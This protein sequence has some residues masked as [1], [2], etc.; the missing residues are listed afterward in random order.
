MLSLLLLCLTLVTVT[1]A[2]DNKPQAVPTPTGTT[3]VSGR[4]IYED[5][6]QPAT[7][8][9]VQLIASQ[10]LFTSPK[11]LRIPTAITNERGEFSMQRVDAGEYY[12]LALPADKHDSRELTLVLAR[13]ADSAA[14]AAKLEQFKKKH[15]R[16][17]VDG[18]HNA[19]VNVRIPN[20]HFGTISGMVLDNTRQ[21]APRA[22]VHIVSKDN[23]SPGVSVVTDDEG[24]YKV[25]G[26]PKGEYV[27]SANPPLK[28]E[29]MEFQGSPGATYFPS[30]LLLQDSPPVV[31]LPDVDT[32]NVDITLIARALRSVAGTVRIHGDNSVAT[33]ATVRLV[34]KGV[35]N[36]LSNY[37]TS[38][39]Q[40]GHW[41]LSNVPDGSYRLFVQPSQIEP[42][43]RFV[44][45]EQELTVNGADIDDLLIEV[46]EGARLSGI[47]TVE[48]SG[49]SVQ[50]IDISAN[51]YKQ[52]AT[53]STRIDEA[54]KFALTGVPLGEI[55][56]SAFAYPEEKFYVKSIESNGAELLRGNLT[57]A[58]GDEIKDVR[59]VIS[60]GVGVITGRVLSEIGDRPLARV[61]VMLR[62]IGEDGPRL[63]GGKITGVTDDRGVFTLSAAPGNYHVI[64]W[65]S[66]DGSGAFAT[67]MNKAT[68]VTL[69]AT[70]RKEIV[71][72]LP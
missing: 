72:R 11:G 16:I 8:H 37:V 47:V 66:A 7:R 1:F 34:V 35:E 48:G 61:D 70:E 2:Q 6:E 54:G 13:S 69:S 30:T 71:I 50:F 59:I 22:M 14:D 63:F 31:V 58:E 36:P 23:A 42:K 10:A 53:S 15:L 46:S 25:W 68:L 45:R 62:R 56:V 27:A 41:S 9:R 39:D 4:V 60:T 32:G 64:A 19:E 52:N 26:L 24:R 55:L 51:S 49:A 57:L 17:N 43:P 33:N 3:V 21:P 65:R 28:G 38:T 40:S 44:Q 18:Q 12:V 5:N 29:R 67:A 20:P